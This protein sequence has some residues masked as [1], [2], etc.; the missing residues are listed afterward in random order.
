[1]ECYGMFPIVKA[2]L[3]LVVSF[4]VLIGVTKAD[5]KR[6]KQFGR[7]LAVALWLVSVC[8]ITCSLFSGPSGKKCSSMRKMKMMKHHMKY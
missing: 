2:L 8:V 5:S 3:L 6:L 4:F 7:I 1:M